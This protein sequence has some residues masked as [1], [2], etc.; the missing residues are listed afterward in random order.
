MVS[1]PKSTVYGDGVKIN[2][3]HAIQLLDMEITSVKR[4]RR[5]KSSLST[6]FFINLLYKKECNKITVQMDPV[7]THK[8]YDYINHCY[9]NSN[10]KK[11]SFQKL[12]K[13]YNEV[14]N[15]TNR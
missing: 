5:V 14:I 2:S 12:K 10:N 7:I 15:L 6:M 11:D 9:R 3:L 4:K 13:I 1:L 8:S